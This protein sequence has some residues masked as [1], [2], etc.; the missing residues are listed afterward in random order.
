MVEIANINRIAN[1]KFAPYTQSKA[2]T[3]VDVA[4][5]NSEKEPLT[6][7]SS[8][9]LKAYIPNFCAGTETPEQKAK[10]SAIQKLA[11]SET[12]DSI[13]FLLKSGILLNNNSNDKSTVLDNLY[14][15]ATTPRVKGLEAKKLLAETVKAIANPFTIT[16][17]FGD[18]PTGIENEILTQKISRAQSPQD[19]N[20]RSASCVATSIEFNLASKQPAEFSRM[21]AG[22][23]SENYSVK[24]VLKLSDIAEGTLEALWFLN[25]FNA[26]YKLKDW[27]NIELTLKPD[28]NAIVGARVQNSYKDPGERSLVDVLLQSTFMNIGSQGT[29]DTLTDTRTGKYNPDNRGLTDIEKNFVEEVVQGRPKVSVTYQILDEEGKLTGYECDFATTQKHILDALKLN[30]N[31][32]IGYTQ[33]DENK[34]VI[35]GHEITIIGT[36][37]TS[38]GKLIFICN[39]T[40]DGNSEPIKWAA[41]ELLPLIHHAGLPKEVLKEDV[42]FVE[43]W[44]EVLTDYQNMKNQDAVKPAA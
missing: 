18:M 16:Q 3:G 31:V 17:N 10:L 34:K 43:S 27:D 26:D 13:N 33:M 39:D 12:K 20:V 42:E 36:E 41:D 19:L 28:R 37:T 7:Y 29:Y 24:K 5:I 11:N 8:E 15:I 35:N 23:S 4:A 9:N 1:T 38:D 44:K 40:D 30:N 2:V 25:E 6:K 32:I 22:I 21:V 14:L